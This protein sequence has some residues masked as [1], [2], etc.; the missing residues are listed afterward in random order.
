MTHYF[1]LLLA[2]QPWW[3]EYDC[4][5]PTEVPPWASHYFTMLLWRKD[6]LH[7]AQYQPPHDFANSSMGRAPCGQKGMTCGCPAAAVALTAAAA[8][9]MAAMAAAALCCL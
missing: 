4:S 2:S 5:P 8:A 3:R 6:T 7:A 1:H 9:A